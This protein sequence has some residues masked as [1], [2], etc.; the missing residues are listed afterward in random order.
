MR[1]LN[2]NG[3]RLTDLESSTSL[4]GSFGRDVI[5]RLETLE[6]S[7]KFKFKKGETISFNSAETMLLAR[8]E[9][10]ETSAKSAQSEAV[11]QSEVPMAAKVTK[12]EPLGDSKPAADDWPLKDEDDYWYVDHAT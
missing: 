3:K 11:H 5:Q 4:D 1:E 7:A 9:R 6:E 2:S 12:L 10:L 8:V